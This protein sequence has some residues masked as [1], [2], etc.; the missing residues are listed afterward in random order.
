MSSLKVAFTGYLFSLILIAIVILFIM[1]HA[2]HEAHIRPGVREC[3]NH[4]TLPTNDNEQLG[5]SWFH[6]SGWPQVHHHPLTPYLMIDDLNRQVRNAQDHYDCQTGAE[7][8]D[9]WLANQLTA[10][11]SI[12]RPHH[13][14]INVPTWLRHI[15]DR[16]GEVDI[17]TVNI[18]EVCN[19]V[20]CVVALTNHFLGD[21]SLGL[22]NDLS[23]AGDQ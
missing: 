22:D 2:P 8:A 3:H 11:Y 13:H 7:F 6:N 10:W 4:H 19:Y 16:A 17:D 9:L 12:M 21:V 20:H 15:L 5:T 23:T 18:A 14:H 1:P